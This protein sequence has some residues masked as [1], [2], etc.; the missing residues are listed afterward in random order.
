MSVL[1]DEA[2]AQ[3]WVR[4]LPGV[5]AAAFTRLERL[6]MLLADENQRQNLVAASSLAQV[7]LRHIADSAQLLAVPRETVPRGDWLDLGTGAG[8]PG[9]AIAILQPDRA[10]T[11]IDSRRLRTAWLARAAADLGLGNVTVVQA[12]VED[13]APAHTPAVISARAFA[14]LARLLSL[15]ARFSTP[16]T[17]WLLPKGAKARQELAELS[18]DWQ[19]TFHVEQSRT[20]ADAGV[21][22][23][24]L[25]AGPGQE[26]NS[27]A[28]RPGPNGKGAQR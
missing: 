18:Q 26:R 5:D 21:I 3:A 4:A 12:R 24:H 14:P 10:V 1:A 11:L 9:L 23:G 7:W 25:L 17:L 28:G 6:V 13:Y 2:E 27:G 8:F 19:H 20:D 16:Q 22:A 15:S